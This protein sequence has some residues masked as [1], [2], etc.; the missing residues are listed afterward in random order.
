MVTPNYWQPTQ[1]ILP[2]SARRETCLSGS[3]P[4]LLSP[5]L[6]G[7]QIQD[8]GRILR[9][10]RLSAK[11]CHSLAEYITQAVPPASRLQSQYRQ[12]RLL[13]ALRRIWL[14]TDQIC[15]KRLVAAIPLWLP[16]YET[17]YGALESLIRSRMLSVSAAT[18]DRLLRPV[19]L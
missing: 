2:P 18:L 4:Q 9:R 15:G 7:R 12:P 11:I 6:T 8:R 5:R 16:P 14:A 10:V 17:Q 1:K 19:R 13:E 3:D